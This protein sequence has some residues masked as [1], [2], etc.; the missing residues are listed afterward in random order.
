M[1]DPVGFS[2]NSWFQSTMPSWTPKDTHA[3]MGRLFSTLGDQ[4]SQMTNAAK[5]ASDQMKEAD[6]D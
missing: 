5:Q 3:F 6:S 4:I 1:T 2:Y